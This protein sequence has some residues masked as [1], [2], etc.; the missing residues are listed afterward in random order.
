M[1]VK[2]LSLLVAAAIPL[3]VAVPTPAIGDYYYMGEYDLNN[4]LQSKYRHAYAHASGDVADETNGNQAERR[5]V[6]D[7]YYMGMLLSSPYV[8]HIFMFACSQ[9]EQP[10]RET[11]HRRLLLHGYAVKQIPLRYI[12]HA[13]LLPFSS[14]D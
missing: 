7:Y 6:G 8:E 12:A 13:D 2:H 5:A 4:T 1:Q 3:A 10:S 11:C 9:R 14:R